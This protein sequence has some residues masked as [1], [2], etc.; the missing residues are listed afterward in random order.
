MSNFIYKGEK[1]REISFPLGGVGGGCIGLAGNGRLIDWE[2]FNRP[3]KGSLNGMSHFAVRAERGGKVLDARILHGDLPPP[4]TGEMA[5]ARFNS[6]FGWGPRRENLCGMPHFREHLFEGTYPTAKIKFAG[7]E[8]F[9]GTVT[10]HAWSPFIP[11]N[12]HDSSLPGAFFEVDIVNTANT[13]IDYTVVGAVSNPF[14]KDNALNQLT[15]HG[16]MHQLT[17]SNSGIA[18]DAP[19]YGTLT[20]G[21]EAEREEVSCQEY[22]YRGRWCDDLEVYWQELTAPGRFSNRTYNQGAQSGYTG[23]DTGH[24]AVHF[25]LAPGARRRVRFV[26]TWHVPNCFNYWR[27]KRPRRQAEDYKQRIADAGL[28]NGWRN[29][30]ATQWRDSADSG[31]YALQNWLRLAKETYCFRDALFNSSLPAPALDAVSANLSTL[32]SPT[33]LRL[34]N[35]TLYGWEGA[36]TDAGSCEGSCTHV[37]NYAQAPAFLFPALERSMREANYAY[38]VDEHGGSH[39]R[40]MLPLGIRADSKDIGP[41]ADG[42][43]GDI[44]K[45]YRDW[46][47]CGD[48]DWLGGLWPAMRRTIEYAWSKNNPFQWDPGESGVLWG[49]QHH[50]LDMELFGPNAWLTGY[51]LAAL[52]AAAEMAPVCDDAEFGAKCR[53]LFAKGKAWADR[54]LFNGEYYHQLIDFAD[55][56]Q[57][58]KYD[59]EKVKVSDIYWSDEHGEIKYQVGEGVEVDMTIAQWHANLYGLGEIYDPRQVKKAL[60]ATFRYNYRSDLRDTPNPW[61]IYALNDEAGLQICSWPAHVRRP[62]IPLPYAQEDQGGYTYAAAIQMIQ[63]G[64]IEEGMLVIRAV[65]DRYDGAK[66]NPWNEIECGS[67]YARAMA[68]F[69]L[70]HAFSG[71]RFDMTAGMIGFAPVEE[72]GDNHCFFWSLASGWGTVS[73]AGGLIQLAVLYGRLEIKSLLLPSV[74]N[75][76]VESVRIGDR[77][78]NYERSADAIKFAGAVEITP[79]KPLTIFAS[80]ASTAPEIQGLGVRRRNEPRPPL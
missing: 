59:T 64:L 4:Y 53:T 38:S 61:R 37:W 46:K 16:N 9:P 44:I 68:S 24:I 10:L 54:H 45:T 6:G 39:F 17:L 19:E 71:F 48:S 30:Y 25:T 14:G 40:L 27:W 77:P 78:V 36:G 34:E 23:R 72:H 43:F 2:I 63:S 5:G 35:G 70:L 56:E 73:L 51:Y 31:R 12:D 11:A 52:K 42:Q 3:N 26:I 60:A 33:C 32:K 67:N 80:G 57:L 18:M 74:K 47:I 7:E 62:H 75:R 1:T 28:E 29:W 13:A 20:L 65:R 50:T 8:K 15:R 76:L 41:C 66:R 79:D 49:R 22:W 55:R 58:K 69:A 21:T